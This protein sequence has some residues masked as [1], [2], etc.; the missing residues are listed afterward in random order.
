MK[1][2]LIFGSSGIAG[3]YLAKRLLYEGWKVTGVQRANK[4]HDPK[5][6]NVITGDIFKLD[7]LKQKLDSVLPEITHVYYQTWTPH[8]DPQKQVEL[9][10]LMFKNA[11]SLVT[12]KSRNLQF[13]FLQTGTKYYNIHKG[14]KA[15][16]YIT[17][18]KEDHPREK[19]PNF[20][21]ALE[22]YLKEVAE[23]AASQG[24]NWT[25]SVARPP[26]LIGFSLG[27]AMNL[28]NTLAAYASL[29]KH[30]GKPLIFPYSESKYNAIREL[31]DSALLAEFI[32][33]LSTHEHCSGQAFNVTNGDWFRW[34][35]V[36]PKVADYFGMKAEVDPNFDLEKFLRDNQAAWEDLVQKHGLRK[37]SL[38]DLITID[39]FR[40]M[41]DR[42]WDEGTNLNKTHKYGFYN[43][44]ETD[45]S[46]LDFFDVLKWHQVIP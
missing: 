1:H 32:C 25:W 20:H 17:P 14:P 40:V 28:A 39:F 7:D 21:Y 12:E 38:K 2:A 35:D 29:L 5:E 41:L 15:G 19:A 33:F 4:P 27:T 43:C 45:K 22:D 30:L 34:K 36:W 26:V 23:Q 24:K 13:V 3:Y 11:L 46:L 10:L 16:V 18:F 37:N 8:S 31:C 42:D 9:N 6:L 44:R